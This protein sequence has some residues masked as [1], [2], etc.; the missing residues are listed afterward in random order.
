MAKAVVEVQHRLTGLRERF[1]A[2]MG[3]LN[4]GMKVGLATPD[5]GKEYVWVR[6]TDW[7]DPQAVEAILES[8]PRCV[9]G[10]KMGQSMRLTRADLLD[11][12]IGSESAGIIDSGLTQRIA[13]DYGLVRG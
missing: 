11:Y 4:L 9:D 12:V 7:K 13:E 6:V 10:Y 2:G 1:I 3:G 5:G 8:Q